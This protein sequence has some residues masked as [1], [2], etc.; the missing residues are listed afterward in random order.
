[1]LELAI[2]G[3]FVAGVALSPHCSL[4]C[5]ALQRLALPDDRRRPLWRA[6]LPLHAGRLVG[7]ALLGAVAGALGQQL[8]RLAPRGAFGI[9]LQL[10]A[11]LL[12]IGLGL[13]RLRQARAACCAPRPDG[14]AWRRFARGM[15]W[16]LVPCASL[17][18]ALSAAALSGSAL[19][20]AL[21][22]AAF[23]AGS[24][25]ELAASG[26]VLAGM[27]RVRD[28]PRV[29]AGLMIGVGVIGV[30]ASSALPTHAL[31]WCLSR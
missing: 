5:G 2:P 17:Y 3:M 10:A 28:M 16:A 31:A 24:S 30:V 29:A 12:L 9:G 26:W 1:M 21:L 6:L 27:D 7:Y 8:L 13:R 18:F 20:A 19:R 23:A 14:S 22:L 4:M 25:P 11:A 15:A